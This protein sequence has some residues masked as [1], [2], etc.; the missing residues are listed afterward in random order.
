MSILKKWFKA[1]TW[2]TKCDLIAHCLNPKRGG[3]DPALYFGFHFYD[4]YETRTYAEVTGKTVTA[5]GS[6]VNDPSAPTNTVLSGI[7]GHVDNVV[8]NWQL[9]W[10]GTNTKNNYNLD[11]VGD[12]SIEWDSCV[13]KENLGSLS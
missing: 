3:I 10:D 2:G 4:A 13:T 5:G 9:G 6:L 8:G 7:S 11:F 1:I 12:F